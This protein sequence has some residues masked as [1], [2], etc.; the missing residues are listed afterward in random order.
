MNAS[1]PML[2]LPAFVLLAAPVLAQ[3]QGAT[4]AAAESEE[5]GQ[6][7]VDGE[8]RAVYLFT[9]DDQG[10]GDTEQA[11]SNCYD[12]CAQAW[13]PVISSTEPQA[14][15]AAQSDLL[16]RIE[17]RDGSMQVAYNGWPLYHYVEDEGAGTATG[18][19]I[20]SFGGEWYLLRP[21]GE[22]VGHE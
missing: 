17:R 15:G 18:Q 10:Q 14:E 9:G 5:Y 1:F 11:V 16:G 4:V 8:G 20:H 22:K 21:E 2:A 6:Y 13:P 19:D 7:L 12:A 3:E